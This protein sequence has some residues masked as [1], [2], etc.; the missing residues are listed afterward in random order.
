MQPRSRDLP[1]ESFL[2]QHA[3]R[4]LPLPVERGRERR[5][6]P[7]P[8]DPTKVVDRPFCRENLRSALV[9]LGNVTVHVVNDVI[10]MTSASPL[11][12]GHDRLSQ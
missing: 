12:T 11:A 1:D 3:R 5:K 6:S 2:S 10:S 7:A 4:L 9:D 8:R